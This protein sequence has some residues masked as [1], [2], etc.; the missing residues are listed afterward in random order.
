MWWKYYITK[1]IYLHVENKKVKVIKKY[2][3]QS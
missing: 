3:S 1:E 2:I